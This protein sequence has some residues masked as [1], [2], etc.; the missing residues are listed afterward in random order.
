MFLFFLYISLLLSLLN[1]GLFKQG[2]GCAYLVLIPLLFCPNKIEN[3]E[4][5]FRIIEYIEINFFESGL[6]CLILVLLE[7]LRLRLDGYFGEARVADY[8]LV[9]K[10]SLVWHWRAWLVALCCWWLCYLVISNGG[11]DDQCQAFPSENTY[12]ARPSLLLCCSNGST[13]LPLFGY[14]FLDLDGLVRCCWE[15]SE[16]LN[17]QWCNLLRCYR[18]FWHV[19]NQLWAVS[20]PDL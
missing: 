6:R 18:K 16:V 5:A 10:A 12:G 13:P 15:F 4:N 7:F 17:V 20:L 1:F 2:L 11:S 3:I 19:I 14:I 8:I 9:M